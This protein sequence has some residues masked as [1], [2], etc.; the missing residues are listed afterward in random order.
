MVS[1]ALS[2]S[3]P[4]AS[5]NLTSDNHRVVTT[6]R[7]ASLFTA[8]SGRMHRARLPLHCRRVAG[9]TAECR[10]VP[11][12]ASKLDPRM[13]N[14]RWFTPLHQASNIGPELGKHSHAVVT[15]QPSTRVSDASPLRAPCRTAPAPP[16]LTHGH[17]TPDEH[18]RGNHTGR[19]STAHHRDDDFPA[20][21]TK[22]TAA[23]R[24]N[25]R[26]RHALAG[27]PD[28]PEP[29]TSDTR[30]PHRVARP[31]E[32][33]SNR[34]FPQVRRLIAVDLTRQ[35]TN[36]EVLLEGPEITIRPVG[37]RRPVSGGSR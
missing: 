11:P 8:P 36:R 12:T 18:E 15:A 17:T 6:K 1:S 13:V 22:T 4:T 23:A 2:D 16:G 27:Q 28:Y 10:N 9:S 26:H 20:A 24:S 35:H 30:G 14:P 32:R 34:A 31:T 5:A 7:G 25:I 3:F 21:A 19:A 37:T 33:S 29:V